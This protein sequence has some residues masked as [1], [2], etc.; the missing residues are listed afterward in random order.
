MCKKDVGDGKSVKSKLNERS[1]TFEN[2]DEEAPVLIAFMTYCGYFF[3]F[4]FGYIHQLFFTKDEI[5]EKNRKNY[6]P[7][8]SSFES[9]YFFHIFRRFRDCVNMPIS[10]VPGTTITCLDRV[11]YDKG[12]T[13]Q[14]TGKSTDLINM[15]SY[16]YLGFAQNE[17]P[18]VNDAVKA[19]EKFGVAICSTRRE[20][21]N[22]CK[23]HKFEPK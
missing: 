15:G 23:V 19:I 7:Y 10:S 1:E 17:G 3:L 9:V 13:F 22:Y 21:G 2:V 5:I 6:A 14:L 11:T 20:L 4:L 12:R 8:L 18:N 16:N